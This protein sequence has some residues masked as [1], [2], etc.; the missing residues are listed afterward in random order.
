MS[1]FLSGPSFASSLAEYELL[2]REW[3]LISHAFTGWG[4]TE[5]KDLSP[6]ERENWLS[7]AAELGK[8]R[9]KDG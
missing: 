6:R 2:V 7:V 4:L 8:L 9:K 5:V 3:A 1:R